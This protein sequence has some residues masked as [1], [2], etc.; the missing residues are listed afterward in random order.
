MSFKE[1]RIRKIT[2]L[3]YSRQDVQQAIFEFAK[4]REICPTYF[5]GFGKS[6]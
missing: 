3:Y 4:N 5:E 1:Q 2:H 6:S